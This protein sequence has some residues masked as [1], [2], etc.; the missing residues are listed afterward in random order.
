[1]FV[2]CVLVCVYVHLRLKS[3]QCSGKWCIVN[4]VDPLSCALDDVW[5]GKGEVRARGER[6]DSQLKG[7]RFNLL[8]SSGGGGATIDQCALH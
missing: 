2:W 6:E 4:S 8:A 5:W 1:M 3:T 7:G